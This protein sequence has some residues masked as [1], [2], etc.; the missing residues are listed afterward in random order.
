MLGRFFAGT[1]FEIN[2]ISEEDIERIRNTCEAEK[3]SVR[4]RIDCKKAEIVA[5]TGQ[6]FEDITDALV[7]YLIPEKKYDVLNARGSLKE[8]LKNSGHLASSSAG[9]S[10]TVTVGARGV[11]KV[12]Q[13]K[14]KISKEQ[15][16]T[17]SA[18]G[19]C[20]DNEIAVGPGFSLEKALKFEKNVG[21]FMGVSVEGKAWINTSKATVCVDPVEVNK[22]AAAAFTGTVERSGAARNIIDHNRR[23]ESAGDEQAVS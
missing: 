10:L 18:G 12:I 19:E 22:A 7:E 1:W 14:A 8:G 16:E 3:R 11:P 13:D 9:E 17:A 6:A 2:V 4:N 21:R 23:L 20:K 5:L 15:K